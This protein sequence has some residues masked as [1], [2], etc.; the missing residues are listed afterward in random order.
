[1]R[2]SAPLVVFAL[3]MLP[4]FGCDAIKERL[5]GKAKEKAVQTTTG[6]DVK[7]VGGDGTVATGAM[8]AGWP[9]SVPQY[10]G[11]KVASAMAT[12]RGKTAILETTDAPAS[13]ASFY[14]DALSGMKLQADVDMGTTKV[15]TFNKGSENVSITISPSGP[16]R[17]ITVS[18]TGF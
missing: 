14:K 6:G 5:A 12:P 9:A 15:L 7:V 11:S 8:P 13:I 10:P 2:R 17:M 3:S 4:L 16:K 1:M 18:V